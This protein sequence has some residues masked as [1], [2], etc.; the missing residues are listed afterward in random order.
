MHVLPRFIRFRFAQVELQGS[1]TTILRLRSLWVVAGPFLE[2]L[3]HVFPHIA[4]STC[5][6]ALFPTTTSPELDETCRG[7][8]RPFLS[9]FQGIRLLGS[10]INVK[11]GPCSCPTRC[12]TL[13]QV[14]V[15]VCRGV[16]TRH[17]LFP[18]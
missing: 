1:K 18:S 6:T 3:P 12:P 9:G 5:A 15:T 7:G 8:S 4:R 10:P 11:V 13:V 16:R 2:P 17:P 14:D